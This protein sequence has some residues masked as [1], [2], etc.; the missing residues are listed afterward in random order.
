MIY[1][2][3]TTEDLTKL[4]AVSKDHADAHNSVVYL[5]P[6]RAYALFYIRDREINWVTCGVKGDGVILYD[7]RFPDQLKTIYRGVSGY[8][9]SCEDNGSFV[10]SKTRDIY[11]CNQPVSINSKVF[12]PDVYEE[13][14]KYVQ[15]GS[16]DVTRYESLSED[17]KQDVFDMMVHSIFKN[18]LFNSSGKKAAFFR[19][20][21]TEAWEYVKLHP[22]RRQDVLDAWAEKI[23]NLK[24]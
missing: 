1:Y 9:Y 10:T 7:E 16:I 23:A 20:H 21:F 17:E 14:L 3:G 6:N 18:D 22:E 24:E 13:L 4:N 2:H 15:R 11:T 12:V 8:I 19:E 5:T